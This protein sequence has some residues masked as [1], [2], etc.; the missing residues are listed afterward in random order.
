MYTVSLPCTLL[1]SSYKLARMV[2]TLIHCLKLFVVVYKCV[3][4]LITALVFRQ[5]CNI[6]TCLLS[7]LYSYISP[8]IMYCLRQLLLFT[9][10]QRCLQ[11]C[12]YGQ[13]FSIMETYPKSFM[14]W[15]L[16]LNEEEE[17]KEKENGHP[18]LIPTS[19]R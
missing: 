18:S 19:V 13:S 1:S 9:C 12:K 11:T 16:N 6:M 5:S 4:F 3:P 2:Q 14:L 7:Y 10:K 17:G 15:V 8:F